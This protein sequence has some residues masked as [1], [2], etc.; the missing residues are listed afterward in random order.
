MVSTVEQRSQ[1]CAARQA[2]W[3]AVVGTA[4]REFHQQVEVVEQELANASP[5]TVSALCSSTW[6][7]TLLVPTSVSKDDQAKAIEAEPN[8]LKKWG[9]G[10]QS[11]HGYLQLGEDANWI[12]A[13]CSEFWPRWAKK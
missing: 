13:P 3:G 8:G 2:D 6:L 4:W 9:G 12:D 7:K 1:I 5:S 11:M 10:I